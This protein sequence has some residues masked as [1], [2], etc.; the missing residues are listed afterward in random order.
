MGVQPVQ[1]ALQALSSRPST[2]VTNMVAT[3]K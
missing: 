1:M 3:L 2:L